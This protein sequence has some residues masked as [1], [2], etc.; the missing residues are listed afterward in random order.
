MADLR[1]ETDANYFFGEIKIWN[2]TNRGNSVGV[3][4]EAS[5]DENIFAKF[6][7]QNCVFFCFNGRERALQTM[8]Q[9]NNSQIGEVLA[10]L[11]ADFDRIL[12]SLTTSPN[13]FYSDCHDVEMMMIN[14]EAWENI[15]AHHAS[16]TVPK[17]GTESKLAKFEKDSGKSLLENLLDCVFALGCMKFMNHTEKLELRFKSFHKGKYKYLDYSKFINKRSLS[18]DIDGLKKE[19]ENKSEKQG[20]FKNNRE[21]EIQFQNL[22]ATQFDLWNLCNG[23]DV[24]NVLSLALEEAVGNKKSGN[25]VSGE[26]LEEF[27]AIGF[28]FTDF[29]KTSLFQELSTFEATFPDG[30]KLFRV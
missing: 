21:F 23:H 11:D 17:N 4:V 14:S 8:E 24:M 25:K 12:N 5:S 13:I 18:V 26:S 27:L 3:V 1:D 28:R 20:F 30:M 2:D 15:V 19:V 9:V 6:F 16:T 29:R 7:D 10:V 22:L